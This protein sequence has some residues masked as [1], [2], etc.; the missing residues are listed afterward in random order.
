MKSMLVR[1]FAALSVLSFTPVCSLASVHYCPGEPNYFTDEISRDQAWRLKCRLVDGSPMEEERDPTTD[2]AITPRK[3]AIPLETRMAAV[4]SKPSSKL[5]AFYRIA[6]RVFR[7]QQLAWTAGACGIR[8]SGWYI[9]VRQLYSMTY[10]YELA[11]Q[12]FSLEELAVIYK[13][14]LLATK[15]AVADFPIDT[16]CINLGRSNELAEIDA[17]RQRATLNYH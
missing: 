17:S 10:D 8:S 7:V 16:G 1:Y 13:R 9:Q 3:A 5:R 12:K 4:E 11:K 2:E 15:K 14:S 6:E